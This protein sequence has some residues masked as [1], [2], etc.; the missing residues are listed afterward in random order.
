MLFV[1]LST[2]GLYATLSTRRCRPGLYSR[3]QSAADPVDRG[4]AAGDCGD[5]GVE[6][7]IGRNAQIRGKADRPAS[8]SS[9][10][11]RSFSAAA[12]RS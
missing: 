11:F 5:S 6:G 9:A 3:E 8:T 10:N 2:G 4:P 12:R 1:R 7:G